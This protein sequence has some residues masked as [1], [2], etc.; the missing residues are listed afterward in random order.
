MLAG[1][2]FEDGEQRVD[3]GEQDVGRARELDREAGVE[4]VGGG[5]ALVEEARGFPRA[6]G[7]VRQEGD[8]RSAGPVAAGSV[9]PVSSFFPHAAKAHATT[10]PIAS[11]SITLL[12]TDDRARKGLATNIANTPLTVRVTHVCVARGSARRLST[13]AGRLNAAGAYLPMQK[14]EKM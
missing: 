3:V 12:A 2:S 1:A 6:L 8:E 7:D 11:R 4:H 5:H 9:V 10:R 14:V 13:G